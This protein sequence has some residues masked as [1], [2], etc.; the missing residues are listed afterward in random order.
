MVG[1]GKASLEAAIAL[2]KIL[3]NRITD[4]IV[5][6]VKKGKLKY[7]KSFAGT[8]PFP[9]KV[10]MRV[11]GEIVGLLK[12]VNS[13]DLV[14]SIISGGGSSLLCLPHNLDCEDVVR[15]TKVLMEKGA[16]IFE[17]NTVRK[18]ISEVQGGQLVRFA[19]PAQVIGLIFSDVP[20]DDLSMVASGPTY[21]D[22]TTVQ[23][24]RHIL[25]KYHVLNVCKLDHCHLIETPKDPGLFDH[26]Y[27]F[28]VTGN[29]IALEAMKEKSKNL[30]Y[31]TIIYTNVLDGVAS[32]TG[33][34][35]AGLPKKGQVVIAAGETVV[36]VTG[37]GK[38]GRNQEFAMGALANL[39]DDEIVASCASDGI[40]HSP[41]AGGLVDEIVKKQIQKMKLNPKKYLDEN[42]SYAFF[43][44]T[45]TA[46]K[47]GI[48][49]MNISDIMIA[50]RKK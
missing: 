17:M 40:D 38:G 43:Q 47:T 50:V 14:I 6:D 12:S 39:S 21:L 48:T 33:K 19:Y 1:I 10:N 37:N 35:F 8:H 41:V 31:K 26:V 11:T 3:G 20:G 18:H 24:A 7:I 2:E 29:I 34:M 27:N 4:G 22:T 36:S 25:K 16:T 32:E 23:D 49:G 42:N 30:G 44:K 5:L 28:Q 13:N 9:S 45:K 15:I 46:L